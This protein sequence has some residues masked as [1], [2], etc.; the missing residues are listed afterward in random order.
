M[1]KKRGPKRARKRNK[2]NQKDLEEYATTDDKIEFEDLMIRKV[3][4]NCR[5]Q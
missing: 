5:R 2:R 4:R 1:T 3:K